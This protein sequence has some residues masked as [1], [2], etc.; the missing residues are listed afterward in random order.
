MSPYVLDHVGGTPLV[1]IRH[2]NPNPNVKILAKLESC[3]PGGSIKDRVAL[4]MVRAAEESGELVP[5][6]TVIEPTSGNTGIGLAMVCAVRGYRVKLLMSENASEER[7]MILRAY[8]AEIEL[9]PGHM[10][11]DGAIE[12][13]YRMAREESDKYVLM[14]QYN[15]PACIDAHYN[16]TGLEI[17]EQTGGEVT[18][19][20]CT[21]GTSGTAMG[22]AKR[23]HEMGDVF[24]AAVEPYAGHKIQG[25]KNMH[26]SYPPGIYDKSKLDVVLRIE[27]EEAFELCR[28]LAHEEGLFVGMSSGA[29]MGGAL[30]LAE[31]MDSGV[32]VVIFPDGGERYLSTPLFAANEAQ[33]MCVTSVTGESVCLDCSG[34]PGLY[35]MGPS[36]DNPAGLDAW[37]RVI[38]LD[39]MARCLRGRGADVHS[40][41]GLS[42]MDDRTLTAARETGEEREAFVQ[43]ARQNIMDRAAS[44]G[45]DSSMNWPLAV[46]GQEKALDICRSLLGH[47][48]AYEKLR[49]VYFD[50]FRDARYGELGTQDMTKVSAGRTVDLDAYVKDNPLDFT[51]LKRATL[52][53]LK[54][55]DVLETEWGNVRPTWFLQHAAAAL[56]G[57]DR[58]DVFLGSESHRFPH[59]ENLR[60]IWSAAGRELQAWMVE[61]QVAA[62]PGQSLDDILEQVGN[63]RAVRL[64]LLSASHHKALCAGSGSV[65]MWVR[66]WQRI[67]DGAAVLSLAVGNRGE[68]VSDEVQQAVFDLKAGFAEALDADI[69]LH[70]FWPVLFRFIKQVNGWSIGPGMSGAAARHCL[71]QLLQMDD[72]L[73]I[74][75]REG[76]PIALSQLPAQVQQM[77]A[78][79]QKARA[80][81]DYIASDHL[82]EALA[83]AGFKVRD[84]TSGPQIYRI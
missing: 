65:A 66:N 38:L 22:C 70:R 69:S 37:R 32:I 33:G 57:L 29:A 50:V 42:D 55:G 24:V 73:G 80:A 44:L 5:G 52:M 47:G 49:S 9:T 8:G 84:S 54:R 48:L 64:W 3:N 63:A 51:L 31:N 23:L 83:K 2:L 78:D 36:L 59:L 20:V 71:D 77:V 17:W 39:V 41:C 61:P 19:A 53:D 82:R 34:G 45:V 43:Q 6:K 15:N 7:R 21:L 74:V 81:K 25:L 11:T 76:L 35:S 13:A 18:H 62:D 14:D 12:L 27:D 10:G 46:Q 56:A 30:K 16:G 26:E 68:D 1:E 79:R 4:A 60:A 58:I 72:V 28:K 75:D 67:Q 40:A